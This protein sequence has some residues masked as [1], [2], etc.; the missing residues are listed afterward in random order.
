MNAR[1]SQER[2][3]P[4]PAAALD[5]EFCIVGSGFSG[6]GM[7]IRLKQRRRDSFVILE[8]AAGIGGTWR[9]NR[10]PGCACDV[11]AHLYSFSFEQNPGW[12]RL[13][14]PRAEI[15]AYL[16]H[17]AVKYGLLGHLRPNTEVQRAEYD[18]HGAFWRVWTSRGECLTCRYLILGVGGLS[19]PARPEIAGIERFRGRT[20]H[21]AEWDP[22]TDLAGQRVA[23]IGTGASAIQLVPRLAERVARLSVFQRTPP[24]VVPKPDRAIPERQRRMFALFPILQRLYRWWIYWIFELRCL[25]FTV[26]PKLM[27]FVARLGRA[28]IRRQIQDPELRRAVTPNYSPGCKRILMA[29]DYYPALARDNVTLVSSSIVRATERGLVTSDGREHELDAIVYGTGFRVAD[30]LTPL[31]IVGRGGVE[32]NATWKTG[33]QAYLGTLISGFP[34]LFMLLGPNTGLGHNSMVFMIESQ[35]EL[36]LRCLSAVERRRGQSVEVRA[37]AQR[38][39]NGALEPRLDKSIWASGCQSWYLDAQ[40]KNRTLWPGFTFEFWLRTRHL[41]FSALEFDRAPTEAARVTSN[42]A[43]ITTQPIPSEGGYA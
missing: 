16:E 26:D 32:L 3:A 31:R 13:F 23:V 28:H 39:Y 34:N 22:S 38:A 5:V 35:I 21:S 8:K 18:E 25:G 30:L 41:A 10:Y 14:A 29:D 1:L 6:L 15:H 42:D 27:R 20:L 2:A 19:R 11:P 12:T 17:C 9:E 36:V 40:G 33:M 4:K 37:E 7:A 24:W 43:E